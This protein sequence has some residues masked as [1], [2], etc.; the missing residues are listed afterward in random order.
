MEAMLAREGMG[1]EPRLVSEHAG[2]YL[3]FALGQEEYGL[4]VLKVREIIVVV[5]AGTVPG[6]CW[7]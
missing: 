2:K 3:T 4:P 7:A 6:T 1:M 5:Y